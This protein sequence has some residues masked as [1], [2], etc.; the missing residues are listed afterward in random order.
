MEELFDK[1]ASCGTPVKYLWFGNT[2]EHQSKFRKV[3]EKENIM[4]E[5]TTPQMHQ[6]N[7]AIESRFTVIKEGELSM[8][9]NVKL[10]DTWL[11]PA[12][13]VLFAL[14]LWYVAKSNFRS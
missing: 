9:L 12:Q 8:I 14:I 2:G 13:D 5:Y 7:G 10:N 11:V 3:C 6:F 1:M 4:L